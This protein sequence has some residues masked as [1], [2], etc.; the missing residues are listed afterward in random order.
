M[1]TV[2]TLIRLGDAQSDLSL[3]WAHKSFCWFC[4]AP[5]QMTDFNVYTKSKIN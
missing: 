2:K 1:R 5:A 3:R 4:H